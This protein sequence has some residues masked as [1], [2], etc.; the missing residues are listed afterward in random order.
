MHAPN[1]CTNKRSPEDKKEDD[2][3]LRWLLYSRSSDVIGFRLPMTKFIVIFRLILQI[4]VMP[5][6]F[7]IASP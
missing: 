1:S 3:F 6:A 5:E 2:V 7:P 4:P